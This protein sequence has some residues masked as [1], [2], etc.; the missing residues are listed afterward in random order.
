[1]LYLERHNL[2][3]PVQNG[4]RKNGSTVD[5]I[6]RFES[7]LREAFVRQSHTVAIFFDIDKAYDT[8]WKH[9]ILQD[10]QNMHLKG[11]P[12]NFIK[13]FLSDRKFSV[14]LLNTLSDQYDQEAGVPQ[15]SIISTTLFIVKI[16]SISD[17]FP[18]HIEKFLYVDDFV[19]CC[20]SN[21]MDIIERKLQQALNKLDHWANANGFKFSRE[22]KTKIIHFCNKCKFHL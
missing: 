18:V 9:G 1:M 21:N 22:K 6:V 5:H 4:F 19:L 15:G 13:N 11:H 8:T 12:P 2:I 16:N 3:S 20:S 10:L 14:Q 17:Y 7:Y